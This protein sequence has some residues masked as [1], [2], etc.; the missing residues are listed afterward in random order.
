M[1]KQHEL[2]INGKIDARAL[3]ESEEKFREEIEKFVAGINKRFLDKAETKKTFKMFERQLK[4]IFEIIVNKFEDENTQDAMLSKKP[5]GG[6]SCV[7]CAKNLTNLNGAI[8]DY[9]V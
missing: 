8:A 7:S 5:L 9:Q 2:L 1:F 3:E 4:N 6:W